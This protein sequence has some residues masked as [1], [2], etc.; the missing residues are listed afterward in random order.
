MTDETWNRVSLRLEKRRPPEAEQ[1]A[2][3]RAFKN[4]DFT[5]CP[6]MTEEGLAEGGFDVRWKRCGYMNRRRR[7]GKFVYRA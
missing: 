3:I 1:I 6:E 2:E 5:D 7:R 4:T